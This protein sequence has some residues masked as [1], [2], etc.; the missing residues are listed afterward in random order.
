MLDLRSAEMFNELYPL[1]FIRMF[2]QSLVS[3]NY[4]NPF[5]LRIRETEMIIST[6]C[7]GITSKYFTSRSEV[8][9]NVFQRVSKALV[10]DF[11]SGHIY[12]SVH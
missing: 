5:V 9:L 8:S 1:F 3:N 12:I 10:T 6:P 2:I 11:D 4:H 7:S